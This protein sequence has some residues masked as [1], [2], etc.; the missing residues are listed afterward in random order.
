ML[1]GSLAETLLEHSPVD[2]EAANRIARGVENALDQIRK[3]SIG[4]LPVE[5]DSEGL[6]AALTELAETITCDSGVDC[7]FEC[8]E[9]VPV[10]DSEIAIHV[11]RIAQEATAN[12]LKHGAPKVVRISLTRDK[13]HITLQ[14]QDDGHGFST[15]T[16]QAN[17]M[18]LK[19]M[20]YRAALIGATL[21]IIP[22]KT[23]GTLVTCS[24][25]ENWNHGKI[26][27]SEE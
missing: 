8:D 13:N 12:A 6:R 27:S 22:N 14:I 3:L 20:Q 19:T 18:G 17:G 21:S 4:L 25:A 2:V 5:V 7:E 10:D 15:T 16:S 23:G 24:L 11:F 1:A 26:H 9:P